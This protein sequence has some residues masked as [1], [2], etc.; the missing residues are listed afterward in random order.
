MRAVKEVV[1]VV[2]VAVMVRVVEEA[3]ADVAVG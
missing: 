3:V 1:G 2:T